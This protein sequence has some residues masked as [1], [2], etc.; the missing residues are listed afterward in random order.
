MQR[1]CMPVPTDVARSI[2]SG[3]GR[4]TS[5]W[6]SFQPLSS[7]SSSFSSLELYRLRSRRSVRIMIMA[8]MPVSSSTI[9]SELRIENQWIWSSPM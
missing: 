7:C 1:S 4:R 5:A 9:A 8:T 6:T 3:G 2:G